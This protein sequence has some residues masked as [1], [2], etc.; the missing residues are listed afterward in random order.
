MFIDHDDDNE[1]RVDLQALVSTDMF[2]YRID[3]ATIVDDPTRWRCQVAM[4]Q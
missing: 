4:D 3:A 1:Y 2:C